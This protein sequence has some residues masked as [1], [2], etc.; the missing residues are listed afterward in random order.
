M[1]GVMVARG[2]AAHPYVDAL[3]QITRVSNVGISALWF[4]VNTELHLADGTISQ[5]GYCAFNQDQGFATLC[6]ALVS[7]Y[8]VPR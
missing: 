3:T 6:V 1:P 4:A 5:A 7:E 2:D 8:C